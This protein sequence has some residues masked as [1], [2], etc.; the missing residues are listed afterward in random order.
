MSLSIFLLPLDLDYLL[1]TY[2]MGI[3]SSKIEPTVF[4]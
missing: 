4:L 1:L 2:Y 3:A